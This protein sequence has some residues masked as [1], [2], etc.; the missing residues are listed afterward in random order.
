MAGR[1]LTALIALALA[2]GLSGQALASGISATLPWYV[3]QFG[4]D[5]AERQAKYDGRLGIVMSRSPDPHLF[6]AWRLL[7]GQAVGR[8]IGA[9]LEVPCCSRPYD[10]DGPA[11]G[12]TAWLEARKVVAAAPEIESLP[13]GRDGADY[14]FVDNCFDDAFDT[15][16]ATLKDRAAA[17]GATSAPV[18]AWLQTQDAVF[19]ACANADAKLPPPIA[20]APA[21]LTTDR[22]YQEAAFA[23]YQG[24]NDEAAK[25][26][27]AIGRDSASPWRGLSPYLVARAR[28]RG[29]LAEKSDAAYGRARSALDALAAAPLQ[30]FGME[31]AL[32][33]M[34]MINYRLKPAELLRETS[35]ELS[36]AAL[37]QDAASAFRDLNNLG[38]SAAQPPAI[39]DWI[40]TLKPR[41]GAVPDPMG[42]TLDADGRAQVRAADQAALAHARER[43]TATRDPAWLIAALSLAHPGE[44]DAAA[45]AADAERLDPGHP[46][47]LTAQYHGLRLSLA[48]GD[49]AVLRAR[50]DRLLARTDLSVNDRNLFTAQRAQLATDLADFSRFAL[51]RRLCMRTDYD[52]P[53]PCVRDDWFEAAMPSGVFDEDGTK[54]TRGLGEDARAVIDRM[55]LSLRLALASASSLPAKL[56]LDIALTNFTRAVQLQDNAAID[57]SARVLTSLLPQLAAD[58]RALLAAK[59]GPDKRFAAFFILAKVPGLRTDLVE[60]YR[61][62]G[63]VPQ[64]QGRWIDWVIPA[65]GRPPGA[66]PPELAAYQQDGAGAQLGDE[67]RVTDLTCLGECGRGAA[68][69][70]LPDFVAA[71]QAQAAKERAYL[72]VARYEYDEDPPPTPPGAVAA[73]D[74]MLAYAAAHP[75]DPRVPEAL[76]WLVRV[77]RWGGSHEHSGRR[78]FKLLHARYPT[79]AWTKKS[80]YFFD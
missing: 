12:V 8:E 79:N 60:A 61:P 18:A 47:W 40:Q 25:R 58:W 10:F 52:Q 11:T 7:H 53:D 34:R 20:D 5:L 17:H 80:P 39:V 66:T 37:P 72:Y 76:Y 29:A 73:W 57:A 54:G 30:T 33:Y 77:G 62:A 22:A 38:R 70:R 65:A 27:A 1:R 36:A 15:A 68:P 41:K 3:D 69:L 19:D 35:N 4:G 46:A 2:A 59:P 26:F 50:L 28:V 51:R 13:T 75:A 48:S 56:R 16:A 64:F 63:T 49:A 45:L 55:P 78:A 32:G 9:K 74:E 42:E 71:G 23:L 44:A 43:W 67:D 31:D 14:T 24:R 6:M 21:W